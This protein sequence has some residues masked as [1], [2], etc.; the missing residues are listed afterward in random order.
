MEIEELQG[1]VRHGVELNGYYLKIS[2]GNF[3]TINVFHDINVEFRAALAD[4][5]WMM[6]GVAR[7][8]PSGGRFQL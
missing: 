2:N 8:H 5:G 6:F 7:G 4:R 1:L 3:L